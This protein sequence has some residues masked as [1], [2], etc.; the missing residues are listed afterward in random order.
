MPSLLPASRSRY[1]AG[2]PSLPLDQFV[3]PAPAWNVPVNLQQS[4]SRLPRYSPALQPRMDAFSASPCL[5]MKSTVQ[6][7]VIGLCCNS[8]CFFLFCSCPPSTIR[9]LLPHLCD[10]SQ[11]SSDHLRPPSAGRRSC[12]AGQ[13]CVR[14]ETHGTTTMTSLNDARLNHGSATFSSAL[15]SG[16]EAIPRRPLRGLPRGKQKTAS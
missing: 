1:K 11:L 7:S 10:P 2:I 13:C 16:E 5:V 12:R 6:P 4:S 8:S 15:S 9:G 14:V 3:Q